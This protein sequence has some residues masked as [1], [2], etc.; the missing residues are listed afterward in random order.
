MHEYHFVKIA[1]LFKK[2][3]IHKFFL[4]NEN[5]YV[6]THKMHD[7]HEGVRKEYKLH[8]SCLTYVCNAI[9]KIILL[10]YISL[11]FPFDIKFNYIQIDCI[12]ILIC[13]YWRITIEYK[14]NKPQ[15]KIT[16]II[17]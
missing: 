5:K 16:T 12:L 7:L 10:I 14:N 8:K 17:K 1:R 15:M 4:L 9:L 6:K 3:F 13:V 11:V 2:L